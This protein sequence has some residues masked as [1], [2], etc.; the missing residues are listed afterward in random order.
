MD[1]LKTLSFK[2]TDLPLRE[3]VKLALIENRKS[4]QFANATPQ[5]LRELSQRI[6]VGLHLRQNAVRY[7]NHLESAGLQ[8][9]SR[10]LNG[11]ASIQDQAEDKENDATLTAICGPVAEPSESEIETA[12]RDYLTSQGK[13]YDPSRQEEQAANRLSEKAP[14]TRS[15]GE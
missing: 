1:A 15:E 13:Q 14:V 5:Q 7:H 10:H 6:G 2:N 4:A 8:G 3:R 12:V 11:L 9:S